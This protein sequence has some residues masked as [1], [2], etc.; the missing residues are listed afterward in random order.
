MK[1][2]LTLF[3]FCAS[4]SYGQVKVDSTNWIAEDTFKKYSDSPLWV[5]SSPTWQYDSTVQELDTVIH[6]YHISRIGQK[7]GI[8][9]TKYMTKRF[10][11][12]FNTQKPKTDFEKIIDSVK[13]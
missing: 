4:A 5:Q 2:L 1:R 12:P 11:V 10:P 9:Q 8:L 6:Y 13:K 7:S 3:I